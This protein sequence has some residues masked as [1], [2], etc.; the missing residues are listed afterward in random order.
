MNVNLDPVFLTVAAAESSPN[1][2]P[3][4]AS[5]DARM[6]APKTS[7]TSASSASGASSPRPVPQ[8]S[9][10]PDVTLRRD[11]GGQVYY[12]LTDPQSGKEL[13]EVPPTVVRAAS[14]GIEEFLQSEAAREEKHIELKG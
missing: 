7:Q 5:K 11:P 8:P 1:V 10:S 13:R 9:L 12:V 2:S 4:P 3:K 6:S 14:Q